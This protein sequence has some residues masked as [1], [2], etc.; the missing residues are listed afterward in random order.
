MIK[1]LS[2]WRIIARQVANEA[3]RNTIIEDYHSQG[4]IS[5]LEM[6]EFM[7]E[8]EENLRISLYFWNI[9]HKNKEFIKACQ[10]ALFGQYGISWDIP[11]K[12]Y[13]KLLKKH[14]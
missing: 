10:E 6:R 14:E 5:E 4:K 7:L 12:E 13:K 1:K 11:S 2:K 9:R 3:V 8:V